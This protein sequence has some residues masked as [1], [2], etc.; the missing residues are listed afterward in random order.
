MENFVLRERLL[1]KNGWQHYAYQAGECALHG[2]YI[3]ATGIELYRNDF[4]TAT[5]RASSEYLK[6]TLLLS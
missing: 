1:D 5:Q 6:P 2:T 3:E 4:A